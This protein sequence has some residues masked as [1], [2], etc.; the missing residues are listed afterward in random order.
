MRRPDAAVPAAAAA[1]AAFTQ[2]TEVSRGPGGAVYRARSSVHGEVAVKVPAVEPDGPPGARI[3]REA[4]ALV[5]LPASRHRLPVV[6]VGRLDDGRP[7]L[8]SPWADGGSLADR[9]AGGGALPADLVVRLG[10][11][12]AEG[13]G[14]LHS[15][16]AVHGAVSPGNILLVEGRAVVADM[17]MPSVL[18]ARAR[19]D[20][21]PP[22]HTPPEVLEGR[23]WSAAGDTWALASTL[24]TLLTGASPFE[25][26]AVQGI[27]QLLARLVT[28]APPE[29]RAAGTP[30]ALVAVLAKALTLGPSRTAGV[31]DLAVDLATAAPGAV[32]PGSGAAGDNRGAVP[33]DEGM[34]RLA[35]MVPV[36][37]GSLASAGRPLGS[38]YLLHAPVGAGAMGQVW[39]ASRAGDGSPV[40]VKILRPELTASPELVSRFLLERTSLLAVQHPNVVRVH[41]LVAE[42]ETLAIV[43][44]LVDGPDLRRWAALTATLAPATACSLLAQLAHGLAAVHRRGIVH[45]DLKPENVLIEAVDTADPRARLTDFGVARSAAGPALTATGSVVGT[46]EYLAP[47]LAAGRTAGPPADIYALGVMAYE[48]LAGV[49]PFAADHPAA[50][51]RLHLETAP[52]RPPGLDDTLW[53]V[54]ARC[55]EKDPLRRPA[56]ATLAGELEALARA[57]AGV[58]ALAPFAGLPVGTGLPEAPAPVAA[59]P[60]SG[61]VPAMVPPPPP[62][63]AGAAVAPLPSVAVPVLPTGVSHHPAPP[64]PPPPPRPGRSRVPAIAIAVATVVVIGVV[65]G[66]AVA[67]SGGDGRRSVSAPTTVAAPAHLVRLDV[68]A[69]VVGSGTVELAFPAQDDVPGFQGSYVLSSGRSVQQLRLPPGADHHTV[70]GLEPDERVCWTISALVRSAKPPPGRDISPPC[71]VPRL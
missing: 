17:A 30:P 44:D 38:G 12:A 25:R 2:W 11:Q 64:A 20:G 46:P 16:G 48:L 47:E 36:A 34:R 23:P 43:M 65:V 32:G 22:R 49:R 52:V 42:G 15:A 24:W 58:P 41:D 60:S 13:L 7:W 56:A 35:T 67:R 10:V 62:G 26:D 37:G 40:A 18:A 55:L 54:V 63:A 6:A 19:G 28:G 29:A 5:Q 51:L 27:P 1:P 70:S 8:A 4:A 66:A 59:P 45:R 53:S 21:P 39:R 50:I 69:T 61:D 71:V 14:A 3:E 57:M 31:H 68:T 33:E 9:L